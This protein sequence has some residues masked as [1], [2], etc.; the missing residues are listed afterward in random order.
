[1]FS[2]GSKGCGQPHLH[3]ATP[4]SFWMHS[5]IAETRETKKLIKLIKKAESW[6]AGLFWCFWKK[7]K[8]DTRQTGHVTGH[9]FH[10]LLIKQYSIFNRLKNSYRRSFL[11]LYYTIFT[12]I[13]IYYLIYFLLSIT[14]D[15]FLLLDTFLCC[16]CGYV[17]SEFL[18]KIN[19]MINLFK[20]SIHNIRVLQN[21]QRMQKKVKYLY[22]W[23]F[24]IHNIYIADILT[25]SRVMRS[26]AENSFHVFLR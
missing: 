17:M 5:S 19:K 7:K 6:D 26:S 12:T 22:S 4:S 9:L 21:V 2:F 25:I 3:H 18:F 11:I 1:M 16:R 14:L 23:G 8:T 15:Y 24:G 13:T 20:D 10:D